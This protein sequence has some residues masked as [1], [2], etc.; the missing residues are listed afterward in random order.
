MLI[1]RIILII[2]CTPKYI[3]NHLT[4]KIDIDNIILENIYLGISMDF[5][6]ITYI[7]HT[8]IN[9]SGIVLKKNSIHVSF[10]IAYYILSLIFTYKFKILFNYLCSSKI[11]FFYIM[12]YSSY[13]LKFL[14]ILYFYFLYNSIYIKKYNIFLF[15]SVIFEVN[16]AV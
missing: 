6:E 7:P 16:K 13:Y 8:I 4:K 5:L 2:M 10:S 12:Y 3:G 1:I 9:I 15:N 14:L 11:H